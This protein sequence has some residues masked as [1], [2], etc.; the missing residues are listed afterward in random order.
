MSYNYDNTVVQRMP[1]PVRGM[2]GLSGGLK[3]SVLPYRLATFEL[4]NRINH[5]RGKKCYP[6]KFSWFTDACFDYDEIRTV[7]DDYIK[8][9]SQDTIKKYNEKTLS[10][11]ELNNIVQKVAQA[12]GIIRERAEIILKNMFW[13]IYD[14]DIKHDDLVRDANNGGNNNGGANQDGGIDISE[15]KSKILVA[16]ASKY[17][18]W[19]LVAAA[20]VGSIAAVQYF[21]KKGKKK[22]RSRK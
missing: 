1:A 21:R 20:G 8:L 11:S 5:N 7:I 17:G 22:S 14:G 4:H 10:Q 16:R 19:I 9:L 18:N 6:I 15:L 13:A 3:K 2:D 12:S